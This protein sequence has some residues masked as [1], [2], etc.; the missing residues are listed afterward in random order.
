MARRAGRDRPR[1]IPARVSGPRDRLP[2][3]RACARAL[4]GVH[5]D[6]DRFAGDRHRREHDD[7]Q[8]RPRAA[9]RVAAGPSAGR[10]RARVLDPAGLDKDPD[11]GAE[12]G[13]LP[14]SEVRPAASEQ[15]HVFDVRGH[16]RRVR[17]V[18]ANRR[19][20]LHGSGQRVSRGPAAHACWRHAGNERVLPRHGTH[21]GRRAPVHSRRR[22]ARRLAGRRDQLRAVDA[23]LRRRPLGDWPDHSR[24]RS[25]VRGRWCDGTRLS[26]P[27]TRRV[28]PA[29][30]RDAADGLSTGSDDAMER[31]AR[32]RTI[33][34]HLESVLGARDRAR[35]GGHEPTRERAGGRP[36]RGVRQTSWGN[37]RRD[38]ASERPIAAGRARAG[39]A[40]Q[41]H[42]TAARDPGRR[43]GRRA[44]HGV[45][46]SRGPDARE[47]CRP[48]ARAGSP[49]RA[50]RGSSAADSC[51]HG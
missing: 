50:G 34:F 5:G 33:P 9:R 49:A 48:A 27:V 12:F 3:R 42:R 18:A 19:L 51:A 43:R 22:S 16:A 28:L 14:R 20:Q 24:E 30:G 21:D 17:R 15:P 39:L 7:V 4:P 13:Q 37:V 11:A 40:P 6:R 46:E 25:A 8:R 47:R 29:G 32:V 44:A 36:A 31:H 10:A 2:S 26:R 23:R 1:T 45:H 35:A 38:S 41:G